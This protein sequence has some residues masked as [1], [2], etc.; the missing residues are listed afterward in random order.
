ML[1]GRLWL[2]RGIIQF[3]CL[4]ATVLSVGPL[5]RAVEYAGGTGE[6]NDPYLIATAE[7]LLAADFNVPGM[8]FRLANDIDL[9]RRAFFVDCFHAHLD[10]AGFEIQNAVV[11]DV[12]GFIYEVM[13]E[14][15]ITNLTMAGFDIGGA[16]GP[17]SSASGVP[18][19]GL[20]MINSGTI[21]NCGAIGWIATWRVPTVGGLVGC[22][23]GSIVNCYFDGWIGANWEVRNGWDEGQSTSVGGLV[24]YNDGSIA[25][26]VSRGF[27][28]GRGCSGGWWDS[29]AELSATATRCAR[30]W[31]T[32][33]QA[34]WWARTPVSSAT[35]TRSVRSPAR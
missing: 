17:D 32:W 13:P 20:A 33:G 8:Y 27:V 2:R 5:A 1:D 35:A 7:Q 22:N 30:S 23:R 10:G 25:N 29:M 28:V 6:P 21:S 34:A 11:T 18:I 15:T 31:E 3:I 19:G 4:W 14:A 16:V 12:A 26:S 9:G 24:A